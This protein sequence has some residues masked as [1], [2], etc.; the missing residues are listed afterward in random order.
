MNI[1]PEVK[2]V[3]DTSAL[4]TPIVLHREDRFLRKTLCEVVCFP[5]NV[6]FSASLSL[7]CAMKLLPTFDKVDMF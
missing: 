7:M 2:H 5:Q 1:K 4:E 3:L 6:G